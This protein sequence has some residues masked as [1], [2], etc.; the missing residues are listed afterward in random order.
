MLTNHLRYLKP[1]KI[2]IVIVLDRHPTQ[3]PLTDLY[4]KVALGRSITLKQAKREIFDSVC[5]AL[6]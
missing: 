6:E 1:L 3:L 2:G 4:D 5:L